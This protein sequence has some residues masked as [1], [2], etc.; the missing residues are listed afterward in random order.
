MIKDIPIGLRISMLSR[1]FKKQMDR[2]LSAYGLTGVQ[3]GVLGHLHR[4]EAQGIEEINQK[5]LEKAAGVTHPTMTEILKRLERGGFIVCEACPRDKRSKLIRSAEKA[6][7]LHSEIEET[8]RAVAECLFKGISAQQM[9]SFME[10][11][12]IMLNNA[13]AFRHK[14]GESNEST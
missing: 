5:M 7:L 4:F 10:V 11:T 3:M 13:F 8:D 2:R 12:D 1:A 14:E 6:R 9:Q